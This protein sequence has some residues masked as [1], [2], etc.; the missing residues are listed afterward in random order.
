MKIDIEKGEVILINKPLEWTSF[1]VVNKIRYAII[2]H[3]R[4]HSPELFVGRKYRPKVG[5]AGTLDP[6]ASGLLIVCAGKETK[7]IDQYMG[8]EKKYTGAIFLGAT[9]PSYDKETEVDQTFD[10]THIDE[11][12]I[13]KTTQQFLGEISQ[14]PPVFSAIKKDG[15]KA[16]QSAREGEEI[17]LEPRNIFIKEFEIV[18]IEMP[19]IH[20]R[21][22]CSKGTY[23][24]SIAY[25][26][27]KALNS[28]AYLDSLC[29]T[30]IG[31][32]KL[33]DAWSVE[34]FVH[35]LQD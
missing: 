10:I 31:A 19:L 1:D 12:L 4:Q 30:R 27:G 32:F 13:L 28:G 34:D 5:H 18:K 21:I 20:F 6:L 11:A 15:K 9:R 25:D 29:R 8:Q 14:I 35:S 24:R 2:K 33:E 17:I 22:V 16:Y 23:I 7:N 3:L 26:F